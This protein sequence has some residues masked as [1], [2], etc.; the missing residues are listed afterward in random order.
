MTISC[1]VVFRCILV[2]GPIKVSSLDETDGTES[3]C[4][5]IPHFVESGQACD[6]DGE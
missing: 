4:T 1:I 6:E 3:A 5:K 2:D